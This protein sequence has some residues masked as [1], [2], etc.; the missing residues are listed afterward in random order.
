MPEV[1][2]PEECLSDEDLLMTKPSLCRKIAFSAYRLAT[3]TLFQYFHSAK[4]AYTRPE[5]LHAFYLKMGLLRRLGIFY[6][7]GSAFLN[8]SNH[9]MLCPRL[10]NALF[11]SALD[12]PAQTPDPDS[13]WK[14]CAEF[15]DLIVLYLPGQSIEESFAELDLL[16]RRGHSLM[17]PGEPFVSDAKMGII[18]LCFSIASLRTNNLM[19]ARA[20]LE[21]A[22]TKPQSR[23]QRVVMTALRGL[24]QAMRGDLDGA[25]ETLSG[26]LRRVESSY[27]GG[28]EREL[29]HAQ[30]GWVAAQRGDLPVAR[31]NLLDSLQYST[32]EDQGSTGRKELDLLI[33]LWEL[34][35][36]KMLAEFGQRE[37]VGYLN[38]A[39]EIAERCSGMN[40]AYAALTK[41]RL[42]DLKEELGDEAKAFTLRKSAF[43]VLKQFVA[44][45]KAIHNPGA[46]TS[47]E[48]LDSAGESSHI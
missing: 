39:L 40:S 2:V 25:V 46:Q 19:K 22:E 9:H 41:I 31:E 27:K 12:Y 44:R 24:L 45:S 5:Q 36:K 20:F 23:R 35:D 4:V 42:A 10:S 18:L 6:G 48:N 32:I 37:C 1:N 17:A 8:E 21:A 15:L 30:L 28:A 3:S 16:I 14:I 33:R 7:V 47:A 34:G 13:F 38:Q 43:P 11:L 26:C 29:V